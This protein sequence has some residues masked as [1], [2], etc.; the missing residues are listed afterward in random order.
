MTTLWIA[1]DEPG[2]ARLG[3]V[4]YVQTGTSRRKARVVGYRPGWVL[5]VLPAPGKESFSQI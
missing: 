1:E 3:S 5:V 2:L 4:C